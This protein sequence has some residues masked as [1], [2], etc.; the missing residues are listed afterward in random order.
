M[1]TI[2]IAI[3]GTIRA[4]RWVVFIALCWLRIPVQILASAVAGL[5][6]VAFAFGLYA[7]PEK[8]GMV[9]GMGGISLGAFA[10]GFF[11]DM[12]VMAVSPYDSAVIL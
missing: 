8:T 6:F 4:M 7:F 9:W 11:Y 3:F 1:S 5:A 10:L 2:K 12:I